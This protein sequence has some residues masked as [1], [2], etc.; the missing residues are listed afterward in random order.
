MPTIQ[1]YTH[2]RSDSGEARD[3]MY[4]ARGIDVQWK[5]VAAPSSTD[6]WKVGANIWALERRGKLGRLCGTG[7][8]KELLS[9]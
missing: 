1:L 4:T 3:V 9:K 2:S 6:K 8:A 5:V 7:W